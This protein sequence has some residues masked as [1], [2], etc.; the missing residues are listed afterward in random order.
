MPIEKP[1]NKS[2]FVQFRGIETSIRYFLYRFDVID[3]KI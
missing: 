1:S 3:I 2:Q